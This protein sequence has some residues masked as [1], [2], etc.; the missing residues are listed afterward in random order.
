MNCNCGY[1]NCDPA[2]CDCKKFGIDECEY[3]SINTVNITI[4][5]SPILYGLD[6]NNDNNTMQ[7][8]S[9]E[10]VSNKKE[11]VNHPDHYSPGPM[12]VI[13]IIEYY[14]LGFHLGNTVKY[15]LRAGVKDANTEIEDLEKGIWYMQRRI[16]LLKNGKK[17][18]A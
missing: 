17:S 16:E 14:K 7:I 10:P 15:I 12:E 4:P 3:C 1:V 8:N 9:I 11:K 5:S 18:R 2:D 13:N 6:N